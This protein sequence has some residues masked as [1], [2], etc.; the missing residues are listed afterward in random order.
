MRLDVAMNT[1]TAIVPFRGHQE[2]K[3]RFSD[4]PFSG[5]TLAWA[6]LEDL[7]DA[8]RQASVIHGIRV[9][10]SIGTDEF[11]ERIPGIACIQEPPGIGLNPAI[12]MAA[13][14]PCVGGT[15]GTMVFLGDLPC[16]R[17]ADIDAIG[18]MGITQPS[19]IPDAAGTG[20]TVWC[21]PHGFPVQT[22]FGQHSRAAHNAAGCT[23]LGTRTAA[24]PW[25]RLRRDVDTHV[26]LWDAYRIGVG[27]V[28]HATIAPYFHAPK[29]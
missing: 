12:A 14:E 8:L 1:W 21:A 28:T 7:L 5:A 26:D 29:Y 4:F 25:P 13:T 17:S 2:A 22:H 16:V 19:F 20:T 11:S 27:R 23:E 9:V 6:M 10:T 3:S 18:V 15:T 24:A